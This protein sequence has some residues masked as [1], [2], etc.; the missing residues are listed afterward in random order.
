MTKQYKITYR[1][2]ENGLTKEDEEI[3]VAEKEPT[4][5]EARQYF[6]KGQHH[7]AGSISII[8]IAPYP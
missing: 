6:G 8:S 2:V 7:G 3:I 1:Y 4:M 5:E